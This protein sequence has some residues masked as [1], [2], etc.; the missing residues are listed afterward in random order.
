MLGRRLTPSS[1]PLAL[2]VLLS[3]AI[4]GT[5][6]LAAGG[7]PLGTYGND[8]YTLIFDASGHFRYLKDKALLLEG[9]YHAKS[10]EVS[11]TDQRGVDACKGEG[12]ETGRYRWTL[13]GG[14]LSFAKI[15]DSCNE[16]IRGMAG[17]WKQTPKK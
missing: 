8:G 10:D 17:R 3:V 15:Q 9:E 7:F 6:S 4:A 13:D 1:I 12:R 16:R 11:L 14:Y 5:P 2:V